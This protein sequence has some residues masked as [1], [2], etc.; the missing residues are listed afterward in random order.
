M[1]RKALAIAVKNDRVQRRFTGL[2][3][4]LAWFPGVPG[5]ANKVG[6]V[7]QDKARLEKAY[8]LGQELASGA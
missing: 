5:R 6:E 8:R 4:R 1:T 7:R 3:E 2:K